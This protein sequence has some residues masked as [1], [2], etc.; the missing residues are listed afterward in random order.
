MYGRVLLT[1]LKLMLLYSIP[2]LAFALCFHTLF[3]GNHAKEMDEKA[4]NYLP[5]SGESKSCHDNNN[6]CTAFQ[7]FQYLGISIIRIIVMFTGELE[8]SSL[9]LDRHGVVH[10][11]ILLLFI[12]LV[13]IVLFNLLNALAVD[14]IHVRCLTFSSVLFG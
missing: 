8:V 7:S 3:S 11:V 13:P 9:N 12:F 4:R 5:D 1:F 14:D 10:Y 2:L 6:S